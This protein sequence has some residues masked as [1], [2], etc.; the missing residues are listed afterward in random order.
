V[1]EKLEYA[2][3]NYGSI[4]VCGRRNY[5]AVL[6]P[7]G[8]EDQSDEVV[9]SDLINYSEKFIRQGGNADSKQGLGLTVIAKRSAFRPSTVSGLPVISGIPSKYLLSS[10]ETD[11]NPS[12]IFI[13]YGHGSYG[14]T[15]G[16][17][18]GVL[19]AQLVC[20]QKPDIYISKFTIT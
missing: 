12:G 14:I 4:W 18:S 13:C 17:G 3:R 1:H 7:P 10:S 2:G 9:I 20:G 15:L 5:V 6:P 8:K 11:S 19:I 16:M